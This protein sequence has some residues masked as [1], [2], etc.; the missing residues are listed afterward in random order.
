MPSLVGN[1][2]QLNIKENHN[3]SG[4]GSYP[5]VQNGSSRNPNGKAL[6]GKKVI[7]QNPPAKP[8]S[9]LSPLSPVTNYHR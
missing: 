4:V 9:P 2:Q 7:F 5:G 3:G 6:G 8:T 1:M